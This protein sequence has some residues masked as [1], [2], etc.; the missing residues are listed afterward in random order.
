[1]MTVDPP[2]RNPPKRILVRFRHPEGRRMTRCEV[3]GK[4]YKRF[5]PI[6]ELV[7]LNECHKPTRVTAYYD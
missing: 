4:T 6:K 5:D 2:R 1:E 3:N 7:V